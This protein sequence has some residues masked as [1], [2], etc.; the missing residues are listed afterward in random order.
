MTTNAEPVHDP[1]VVES[2]IHAVLKGCFQ[3]TYENLNI[4]CCQ[5]GCGALHE[6]P[7]QISHFAGCPVALAMRL[8]PRDELQIIWQHP[9]K[10]TAT[11]IRKPQEETNEPQTSP[12]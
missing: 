3:R 8:I 12:G 11:L 2:L 9:T 4:W 5:S 1:E 7:R 10:I 6:D